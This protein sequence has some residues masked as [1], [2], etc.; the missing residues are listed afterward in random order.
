MISG[1]TICDATRARDKATLPVRLSKR[2]RVLL[3]DDSDDNRLLL[4]YFLEAAGGLV[5]TAVNGQEAVEKALHQ[6]Y[7]CILMD[8]QMPVLDGLAAT[9]LLRVSGYQKPIVALTA[10]ALQED[11]ARS[12]AAGCDAHLGKPVSRDALISTIEQVLER[13]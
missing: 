3:V 7:D 13:S 9:K 11:Q 5:D 8:I 6:S 10:H 2:A 12:F 1:S 4:E